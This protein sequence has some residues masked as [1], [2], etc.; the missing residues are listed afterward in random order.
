MPGNGKRT[1]ISDGI[2]LLKEE[3]LQLESIQTQVPEIIFK[4]IPE[5]HTITMEKAKEK[6]K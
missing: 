1:F 5:E 2:N 4:G 3:F 6:F